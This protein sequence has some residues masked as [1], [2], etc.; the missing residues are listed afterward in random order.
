MLPRLKLT[1]SR[2]LINK[3]F[4]ML[5]ILILHLWH[6]RYH[7][8]TNKTWTEYSYTGLCEKVNPDR[9]LFTFSEVCPRDVFTVLKSLNPSKAAGHDNIPPRMIK[10]GAEELAVPLCYLA[11]LS[12]QSSLFPTS[13]K[14]AKIRPVFKSNDRSLLD[15][16]RPI[17]ILSVFSKVLEKFVYHQITWKKIVFSLRI[18]LGFAVVDRRSMPSL[19]LRTKLEKILTNDI[20][21]EPSISI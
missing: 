4:P 13:E 12:L 2:Q 14:L 20:V 10:D 5:F 18:N 9:K 17:S 3:K 6:H 19:I 15:N 11:N 1:V 8:L 21:L 16:Y 7:G